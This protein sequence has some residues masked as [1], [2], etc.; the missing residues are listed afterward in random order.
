MN[1]R[2][3]FKRIQALGRKR[4]L[5]VSLDKKRGKGSHVKL[6]LGERFTTLAARERIPTGTLKA[7]CRHLGITPE[8]L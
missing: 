7:M 5:A 6:S 4:G 3:F 2:Q 1:S 8:D